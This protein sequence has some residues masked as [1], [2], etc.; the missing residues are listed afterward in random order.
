MLVLCLERQRVWHM[1]REMVFS[2]A[3]T[4]MA[5]LKGIVFTYAGSLR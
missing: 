1:R 3:V 4:T 5:Y 2:C